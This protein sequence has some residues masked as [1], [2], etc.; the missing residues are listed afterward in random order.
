MKHFD[1]IELRKSK[2]LARNNLSPADRAKFSKRIV[3][4]ILAYKQFRD[5]QTIMI[6]RATKGE[7]SLKEL[8]LAVQGLDKRLVY[9]LCISK[10]EMVALCPNDE[11]AWK[12]GF[13]GIEEPIREQSTQIAPQDI[14]MIICPCTV[15]DEQGG[16]MGMGAGF[17]DR[18]LEKCINACVVAVA[19]EVQKTES[20][21]MEAWDKQMDIIFTEKATYLK[22]CK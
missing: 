14:D 15:F 11:N 22:H 13:C 18:F 4:R 16:R 5:A 19:F 1:R 9:P 7:V 20:V 8:E 6:Y 3:E 10:S 17:Y 2:I 12:S 21:P